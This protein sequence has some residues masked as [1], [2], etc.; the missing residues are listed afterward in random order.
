MVRLALAWWHCCHHFK[1]E[2]SPGLICPAGGQTFTAAMFWGQRG[3]KTSAANPTMRLFLE[4]PFA[5]FLFLGFGGSVL[6]PGGPHLPWA[7][8]VD[9]GNHSSDAASGWQWC[10][11][12]KTWQQSPGPQGLWVSGSKSADGAIFRKERECKGD[13]ARKHKWLMVSNENCSDVVPS[14][15]P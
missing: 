12:E 10:P 1:V 4:H 9:L 2:C 8:A 5:P 13:F 6:L 14:G 7:T 11:G 3:L 15:V